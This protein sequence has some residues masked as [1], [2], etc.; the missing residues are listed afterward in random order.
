MTSGPSFL[1]RLTVVVRALLILIILGPT[2]AWADGFRNPFQDSA[3][4]AQGNAFRAQVDNPSAIFYN[5]AGMTQLDGVQHSIGA[6]FVSPNTTFTAPSGGT[7]DNRIEGGTVG[8]PPPAQFFITA[9]LRDLDIDFLGDLSL[10]LGVINL[11]GFANEY[12]QDGPFATVLTKAQFPLLDFKPTMAY[13]ISDYLSIGIGADIFTFL[14]FVADGQFEQQSVATGMIPG[15]TA[16]DQLEL[17]GKGTTAGLNLSALITPLRTP[18]GK[19]RINL[20]F[21]WRSQAVLPLDGELLANGRKVADASTSIRFPET[22]EWGIAVWPTRNHTHEWKVE[23]DV[24]FV[25]WSSIRNF[26]VFLSNGVVIRNPQNWSDAFTVSAGT[27]YKWVHPLDHPE[28]EYAA[29]AGYNRTYTPVPDANFNP[30]FPD[31]NINAITVGLGFFCQGNGH[32]LWIVQCGDEG[33]RSMW[34]KGMAWDLAYLVALYEPRTVTG[35]PNPVLNGTYKTTTHTGSLTF[36]L[37]F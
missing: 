14:N 37:N 6:Q 33:D 9:N 8:L 12:P 1:E 32:F 16:G 7:V 20:G 3:A 30:A 36:R 10:G 31:S 26:D 17:S 11:F 18:E 5:P 27:E 21:I 24:D 28:W 35:N 19:P 23:V 25:R 29:R 13:K 34:R 15:T 22:Y 2:S 4:I